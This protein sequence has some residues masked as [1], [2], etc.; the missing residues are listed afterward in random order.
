MY[1][2]TKQANKNKQETPHWISCLTTE[3]KKYIYISK[4]LWACATALLSERNSKE[5]I[6]KIEAVACQYEVQTQVL[7]CN[8]EQ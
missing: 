3:V 6:L 5:L 7:L 1:W 4:F 2:D 8:S